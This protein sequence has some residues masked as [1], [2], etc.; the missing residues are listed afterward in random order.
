MKNNLKYFSQNNLN[1]LKFK[2]FPL[3]KVFAFFTLKFVNDKKKVERSKGL[4][5]PGLSLQGLLL[6]DLISLKQIHSNKVFIVHNKNKESI[7]LKEGDGLITNIGGLPL[8]VYVA[9]CVAIYFYAPDKNVIAIA[10]SGW[11]GTFKKITEKIIL[12]MQ[13]I[14]NINPQNL[15]CAISPCILNCCYEVDKNLAKKF[16]KKFKLVADK[17]VSKKNNK[18]YLNLQQLNYYLLLQ[19]GVQKKNIEVLNYCTACNTKYFYSY[20]KEKTAGRMLAAIML[21]NN[22]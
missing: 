7:L 14:F 17:V 12:K 2:K 4:S 22:Y 1:Y 5:L 3:K 9:D 11:R 10:H 15:I 6:Q 21:K 20:R 8:S 19:N 13:K 16:I 18:F